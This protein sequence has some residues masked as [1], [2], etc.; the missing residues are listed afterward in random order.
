[1]Y[2]YIHIH[3]MWFLCCT[4]PTSLFDN[5]RRTQVNVVIDTSTS[6]K[7]IHHSID[8]ASWE[9]N[10]AAKS[11]MQKRADRPSPPVE[12]VRG[13]ARN[14]RRHQITCKTCNVIPLLHFTNLTFWQCSP[15]SSERSNWHVDVKESYPPQHWWSKLRE[16]LCSQ[17]IDAEKG[18]QTIHLSPEASNG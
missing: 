3:V 18:R 1:M 7:V 2:Q 11:S 5:A 17:I 15:H 12:V 4:S 6:K 9:K 10:F 14:W 8:E 13:W 16:K